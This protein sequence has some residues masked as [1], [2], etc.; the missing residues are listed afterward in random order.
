[1]LRTRFICAE[2]SRHVDHPGGDPPAQCRGHIY[3]YRNRSQLGD[4][5]PQDQKFEIPQE[6]RQLAEE[7]VERARQLYGSW[8]AWRRTWLRPK[9]STN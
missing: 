6:L 1:M 7:N 3:N 5:M 4:V 2:K 9:T 8:M